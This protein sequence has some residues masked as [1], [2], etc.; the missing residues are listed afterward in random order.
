MIAR[1]CALGMAVGVAMMPILWDCLKEEEQ[2]H[3]RC[4]RCRWWDDCDTPAH[5]EAWERFVRRVL[6][7]VLAIDIGI[8]LAALRIMG[9][10]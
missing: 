2:D 1:G 10:L 3:D 4:Y 7:L 5:R 8:V 6:P 9:V